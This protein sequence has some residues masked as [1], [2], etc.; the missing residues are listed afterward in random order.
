MRNPNVKEMEKLLVKMDKL[1][2]SLPTI[3]GAKPHH[4]FWNDDPGT[5][6][7]SS[8]HGDG[9][10]DYYGE[11]RGG[12]PWIHPDLMAWAKKHKLYWEWYDPSHI[13]AY[14]A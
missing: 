14:P 2:A 13:A 7:I 6:R 5:L 9:L 4:F 8:E 10:V 11:F 3:N 12:Y 1:A